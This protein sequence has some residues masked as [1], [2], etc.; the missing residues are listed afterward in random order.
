[1][2]HFV[3]IALE[4]LA[5]AVIGIAAGM[6]GAALFDALDH[7]RRDA[8]VDACVTVLVALDGEASEVG[9]QRAAMEPP[10]GNLSDEQLGEAALLASVRSWRTRP[11]GV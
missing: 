1:M 11:I 3:R 8:N 4:V 7:H 6:Y 2:N 5:C 9:R 10:C